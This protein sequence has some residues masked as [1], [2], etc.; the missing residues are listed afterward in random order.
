MG[1]Q[2]TALIEAEAESAE[3]SARFI[4]AVGFD[5]DANGAQRLRTVSFL[6]RRQDAD[7]VERTHRIEIPA[8][9]LVPIP[10]LTI[11]SAQIDFHATVDEIVPA[12]EVPADAAAPAPKRSLTERIFGTPRKRE[13][14]VTRVARSDSSG[15]SSHW[16]LKV[17]IKLAQSPFPGGIDRLLAASDLAVSDTTPTPGVP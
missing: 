17:S 5:H 15:S 10:L 4:Q 13:K 2:L 14:L 1:A 12:A 7:G 6:M 16:S 11:E 8:L 3:T 9:T